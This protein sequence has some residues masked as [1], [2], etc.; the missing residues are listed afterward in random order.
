MLWR[1]TPYAIPEIISGIVSLWLAIITWRRRSAPGAIFFLVLLLAA[2]EY[3]LGYALELGSPDLPTVLF[4]N[5]VEWLGVVLLPLAW[6]IFVLQYTGQT[7][8]LTR[9][10][11]V[12]LAIV[13]LIPLL[14]TWTNN[15]HG[16]IYSN[17][18]LDRSVPF[19]A[20]VTT[21]GIWFWIF[22]LYTYAL[23]LLG[24]F[25]IGSFIRTLMRSTSLY[26]GQ[27]IALLIAVI[28]PWI[29][30]TLSLF[31]PPPFS[32]LDFTPIGFTITRLAM[33]WSLFRFRMLDLAP[34]A[35]NVVVESMS[36]AVIVTDL[37]DRITDLN[38][39]AERLIGRSLSQ[40]IGQSS[41]QVASAW[42]EQIER[43]YHLTSAHEELVLTV[44]G[45]LHYFDLRISPLSDRHGTAAGRLV[46]AP[47][48]AGGGASDLVHHPSAPGRGDGREALHDRQG[49]VRGAGT[50]RR[51]GPGW[52]S[53]RR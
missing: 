27:A 15:L 32:L 1:F 4:W 29:G 36:D 37:H 48:S 44:D 7:R 25:L 49:R 17:A 30:N 46:V 28:A 23:L 33:A 39:A 40:V 45:T 43:F 42:S 19:S 5:N 50:D 6:L 52:R 14:L 51:D 12:L 3:S 31:G 13:P 53:G 34:V 35:R 20:L 41:L 10:V 8:W 2:A 24:A 9:R 26:H 47:A 21:Y 16:L 18:R 22:V 38:P 11:V